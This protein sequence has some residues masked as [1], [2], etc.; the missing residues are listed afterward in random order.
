MKEQAMSMI[1]LNLYSATSSREEGPLI[2]YDLSA[3]D[4]VIEPYADEEGNETLGG[5]IGYAIA[6]LLMV[7]FI[8]FGFV[9]R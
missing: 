7:A 2:T 9:F 4:R 1:D 5:Q 8:I 6:Y 3:H